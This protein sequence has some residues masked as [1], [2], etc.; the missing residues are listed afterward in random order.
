MLR[1]V[2]LFLLFVP[3]AYAYLDPATSSLLLSSVVALIASAIYALKSFFY[4]ISWGG[5]SFKKHAQTSNG[6]VIY[7]EDKRYFSVFL[8]ILEELEKLHVPYLYYTN[9]ENDPALFYPA[10]CGKIECI[11]KG[12]NAWNKLNTLRAD[13]LLM[14]T[15]QLNVLQLKRSSGVKHYAHILHGL[16][17]VDIYEIFALDYFDSVLTNSDI[18]TDFIREV[19]HIRQLK[20]KRIEVVGCTYL[21]V[22]HRKL[23]SLKQNN[24]NNLNDSTPPPLKIPRS[25]RNFFQMMES[26]III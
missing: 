19:E 2:F 25:T 8:P 11:G 4:K 12:Q 18:H 17:H 22:L 26:I 10:Q 14:T 1:F 16:T 20:P 15:P 5:F 9:D 7:G 23:L 24:L 6:I 13:V 21:D 3:N